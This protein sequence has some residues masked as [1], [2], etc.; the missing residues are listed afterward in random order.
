MYKHYFSPHTFLIEVDISSQESERSCICVLGVSTL[1]I[2]T[3]LIYD[4][5]FDPTVWYFVGFHFI[6]EPKPRKSMIIK[7]IRNIICW[8]KIIYF[9]YLCLFSYSG[10]Q[11]ILC[12]IFGLILFVLLPN[13]R[14]ASSVFSNVDLYRFKCSKKEHREIGLRIFS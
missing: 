8:F 7:P 3:T 4:F 2:S 6:T 10:F 12:C 13:F 1:L 11:H 14:I 5:K 9:C